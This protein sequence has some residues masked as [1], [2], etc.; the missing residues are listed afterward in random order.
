M[1]KFFHLTILCNGKTD[2]VYY[3]GM[4]VTE[5]LKFQR[6]LGYD[7]HILFM[8]EVDWKEYRE[9]KAYGL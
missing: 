5:F 3:G 6:E 4:S 7:T 2:T 8:R 1:I 9:G